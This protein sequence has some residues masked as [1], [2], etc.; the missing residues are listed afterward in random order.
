MSCQSFTS[1]LVYD[2]PLKPY[3]RN[4]ISDW[5]V[6][7]NKWISSSSFVFTDL[8]ERN[9][10]RWILKKIV[11]FKFLK[12]AISI[13]VNFFVTEKLFSQLLV[14]HTSYSG[15]WICLMMFLK[16]IYSISSPCFCHLPHWKSLIFLTVQC[17]LCWGCTRL[18]RHHVC[19]SPP[20][21]SQLHKSLKVVSCHHWH[22]EAIFETCTWCVFV[23]LWM[24]Q[25]WCQ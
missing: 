4:S 8:F 18:W 19:Y 3:S 25:R 15:L 1:I 23:C 22:L 13:Y 16:I 10:S 12:I 6:W 21:D 14:I 17:P 24:A 20:H 11:I 5:N 7:K 9:G 2:R